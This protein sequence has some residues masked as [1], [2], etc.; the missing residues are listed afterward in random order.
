MF[1]GDAQAKEDL[2]LLTVHLPR[3]QDMA[4]AAHRNTHGLNE[5]FPI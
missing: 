4:R 5:T 1:P 2:L 3:G